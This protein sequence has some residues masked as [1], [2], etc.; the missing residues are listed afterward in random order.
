MIKNVSK[1]IDVFYLV[2]KTIERKFIKLPMIIKVVVMYSLLG[3]AVVGLW[4]F[5]PR[6]IEVTTE[7]VEV[8]TVS[9]NG[10]SSEVSASPQVVTPTINLNN[11]N[12]INIYNKAIEEGLSVEQSLL[13]ISISRH[14]TGNWTSQVFREY[15]NFGGIMSNG[16]LK[17]YNSYE[18][19]LQ[20]FIHILKTY[21]FELGLVTIEQIGNKYCPVG[22]LNDP[23]G[24]NKNWIPSVTQIYNNYL[25]SSVN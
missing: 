14:E 18:E 25:K 23:T 12:E 16:H 9:V 11:I 19:G 8:V 10:A 22:A 13:V 7:R 20:D 1:V 3:L 17:Q 24:L 5:K 2:N 4:N 21:Y 6:Y 15:N